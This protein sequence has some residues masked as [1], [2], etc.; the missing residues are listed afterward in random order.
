MDFKAIKVIMESMTDFGRK[1]PALAFHDDIHDEKYVLAFATDSARNGFKTVFHWA[2]TTAPREIWINEDDAVYFPDIFYTETYHE[3]QTAIEK[4]DSDIAQEIAIEIYSEIIM[5]MLPKYIISTDAEFTESEVLEAQTHTAGHIYDVYF[6]E[7]QDTYTVE[8]DSGA[9]LQIISELKMAAGELD[10][11][12]SK[13]KPDARLP[14]GSLTHLN[15]KVN[16]I[17]EMKYGPEQ[18]ELINEVMRVIEKIT[19]R[20]L[21]DGKAVF[22]AATVTVDNS[23][24]RY[25]GTATIADLAQHCSIFKEKD[26]TELDVYTTRD[27]L[28]AEYRHELADI[29]IQGNKVIAL[30]RDGSMLTVECLKEAT[31]A[32]L[33]EANVAVSMGAIRN[34]IQE[35]NDLITMKHGEIMGEPEKFFDTPEQAANYLAQYPD[36]VITNEY[37]YD[38]GSVIYIDRNGNLKFYWDSKHEIH[39]WDWREDVLD[40]QKYYAEKSD[41]HGWEEYQKS[42]V[43]L[44]WETYRS[45]MNGGDE[46]Y[47]YLVNGN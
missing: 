42:F 19:K 35:A 40:A 21:V 38:V 45:I 33:G 10:M 15:R 1:V 17:I 29:E 32:S 34:R 11:E 20:N 46:L 43:Y 27:F 36:G 37:Y 28:K 5:P 39:D 9:D 4:N 25:K 16:K 23:Q 22:E 12:R 31:D 13:N 47:D 3:L 26:S 30:F 24:N 14:A 18:I 8:F 41:K 2:F 44:N 7:T 6:P